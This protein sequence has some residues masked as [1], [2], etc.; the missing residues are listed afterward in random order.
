MGLLVNAPGTLMGGVGTGLTNRGNISVLGNDTGLYLQN[1]PRSAGNTYNGAALPG[2]GYTWI[3]GY[4]G[5]VFSAYKYNGAW[6]AGY[7]GAYP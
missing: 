2:G 6:Y 4:G 1:M 5:T 7:S 3:V